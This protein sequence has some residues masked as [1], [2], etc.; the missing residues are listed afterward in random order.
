LVVLILEDL[1]PSRVG[2]PDLHVVGSSSALDIPRLVVQ[3]CSN[4]QRLLV[5]VPDLGL[6]SIRSLDNHVSVV[7]QV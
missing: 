4:G 1:E 7:D 5:E 6:S 3:S 2:A